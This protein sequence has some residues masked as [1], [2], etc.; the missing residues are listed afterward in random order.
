VRQTVVSILVAI[1]ICL[2]S[3][4]W[5]GDAGIGRL[6]HTPAERATLEKQREAAR[7]NSPDSTRRLTLSGEIRPQTGQATR[8]LNGQMAAND[9]EIPTT[10]PPRV[11]DSLDPVTGQREDLLRGGSLR[12]GEKAVPTR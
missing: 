1:L 5:A 10:L 4:A 11:G 12:V 8:W 3:P 6:F 2:N 7:Q 9:S